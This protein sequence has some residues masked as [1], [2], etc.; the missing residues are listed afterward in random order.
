MRTFFR[1]SIIMKIGA[2]FIFI[3]FY[4]SF[5]IFFIVCW[6]ANRSF[7]NTVPDFIV[8]LAL[9]NLVSKKTFSFI[10]TFC[11][12]THLCNKLNIQNRFYQKKSCW[13]SIF[14]QNLHHL[15]KLVFCDCEICVS[16]FHF[17][18]TLKFFIHFYN[19]IVSH[20]FLLNRNFSLHLWLHL[21]SYAKNEFYNY[22]L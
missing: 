9:Y 21:Y 11:I 15:S 19:I 5:L 16:W 7:F 10:K 18:Q 6:F 20:F 1:Y 17:H 8:F 3:R 13:I 4:F 14:Y 2:A 22:F 12:S